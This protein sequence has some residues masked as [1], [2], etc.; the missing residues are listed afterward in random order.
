MMNDTA[1]HGPSLKSEI[2]KFV[3]V[4]SLIKLCENLKQSINHLRMSSVII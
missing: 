3:K 4:R 1:T 2:R